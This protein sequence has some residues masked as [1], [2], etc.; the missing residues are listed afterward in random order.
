MN[1]NSVSR[2][3]FLR[4]GRNTLVGLGLGTALPNLFRN[5]T[6]AASGENPADFIRIGFIGLGPQGNSNLRALMANAVAVCDVDQTRL[7]AAKKRVEAANPKRP[8]AAYADYRKLLEDKSIDA[9]LIATPDHWHALPAIQACQAGKDVYCEKPLTL[10]IAEGIALVKAARA[11]DRVVQTG[12][13]QRSE[14]K[15]R[16]GCEFVRDDYIGKLKEVRVGLPG[17]N[18]MKDPPV[19]DGAP[20]PELDYDFWLGPAPAR[21][22]NA[23]RVHY[24]FRFFWD[25]SGGQ[26]T[27]WGAHHLDIA[28]WG[29]GMD[30]SGPVEI[31]GTGSFDPQKRF[32][33]PIAFKVTYKYAN[34]V[35]LVCESPGKV[36]GT[37][38]IG[39]K[40][41]IR[42]NRG[43]LESEPENLALEPLKETDPRLYVSTEHRKN[44][45][46]CIKSRQRPIC[47]V[48][49]GHRSATVCH[50][51]NI[52]IRTG[53]KLKWDPLK[54]Q[55][56]G[57]AALAQWVN[58]PYRAPWVLP[59]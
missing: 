25:Y 33:T 6:R 5:R 27:N 54:Q 18:W 17:V 38:F 28:Q 58:R 15:F 10:N 46:D 12:S 44:W 7:A 3:A 48:E 53:K 13:Q 49:I 35:T 32:E 34:G 14:A 22:Y 41:Q 29:L 30:E 37:T 8:C 45:L 40:G 20:P 43:V 16:R 26:M 1:R 21:R 24:Y 47:D 56:V 39:D 19:P 55:I 42:V 23:Q 11:H 2:R 31:S 59:G 9:V 36:T 51:G 50:L 4:A 52:A 57:D